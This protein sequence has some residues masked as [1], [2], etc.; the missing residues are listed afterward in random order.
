MCERQNGRVSRYRR[1]SLGSD[2][3]Y[4]PGEQPPDTGGWLKLNTNE[5]PLP[6]SPA[7]EAA[8][9]GIAPELRRYPNP[10]AEPLRSALARHHRVAPEQVLVGNGADQLLD[11]CFRA[12]VEPGGPVVL[13]E[14]TYSLLPVLARMFGASVT[15][16][17]ITAAGELPGDLGSRPAQLRVLVNP[18]APTGSWAEPAE[19]ERVL[20]GT[21]SVV[22]IDEA[23]C[24]F[25][26][27]SCVS[28]LSRH[29]NWL[30]V[31]TFSK[32]YALAGL[33]VGYALGDADLIA[34]LAAV[35]DS[36]P[37]DRIAIAAAAA[38]LADE[39]HHRRIVETVL[40][41]RARISESLRAAGWEVAPSHANFVL[42]RPP[43]D[44]AE[45][46]ERLRGAAILVRRFSGEAGQLRI[47][48]GGPDEN[49]RLL[50]AL[51]IGG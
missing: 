7:V 24:D 36:Y 16:V 47:S 51:G 11:L 12:F 10:F 43:A 35:K 26:P 14:P 34:D 21:D 32:S 44:A 49:D 37:V 40:G 39:E 6:P 1:Q 27:A 19:V 30:V 38:A 20:G 46:A 33:R 31:R 23:Y 48:I 25:A 42:A 41:E 5:A 28:A 8:I 13:T 18:N 3:G 17:P 22:V 2:F 50:A 4:T 29:P 9:A 45:V 15:A